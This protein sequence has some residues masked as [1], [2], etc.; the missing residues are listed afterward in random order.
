MSTLNHKAGTFMPANNPS[1]NFK[2]M[3]RHL[4]CIAALLIGIISSAQHVHAQLD[5]LDVNE[6]ANGTEYLGMSGDTMKFQL[7]LGSEDRDANNVVG[8]DVQI[9]FPKLKPVPCTTLVTVDGTW[10]ADGAYNPLPQWVSSANNKSLALSFMRA[11]GARQ[12]GNG[13]IAKI[14]LVRAGGF[15]NTEAAIYLD[16]GVIMVDNANFRCKQNPANPIDGVGRSAANE[17]LVDQEP[18]SPS[19]HKMAIVVYPNPT[20]DFVN[21]EVAEPKGCTLRLCT[22]QSQVIQQQDC[23]AHQRLDLSHLPRGTYLLRIDSETQQAQ[24]LIVRR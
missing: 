22:M 7:T 24:Q 18:H 15:T 20:S 19:G 5:L 1:F 23:A 16:G 13:T 3:F 4:L 2:K 9:R 14:F 21:V 6:F 12:S 17:P 8:Y 10:I 11:D